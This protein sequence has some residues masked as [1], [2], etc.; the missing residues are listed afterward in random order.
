[1]ARVK[2]SPRDPNA[3]HQLSLS[4]GARTFGIK[5]A[6]GP[7]GVQETPQTPSNIR[8]TGGGQKYGD[9]DP[10]M[11]HLEQRSWEGGRAA[12]EYWQHETQ[13]YDSMNCYTLVPDRAFPAPQW[14]FGEG[15]SLADNML[16]GASR[17]FADKD[18]SWLN[19]TS[20]NLHA[21]S[22]KSDG[23]STYAMGQVQMW[24]RRIGTPPAQL[25]VSVL[26]SDG[27]DDPGTVL[28]SGTLG[29]TIIE[30]NVSKLHEFAI[31]SAAGQELG[32]A[33][34]ADYFV[35][36]NTTTAGNGNHHWEIGY[37]PTSG[38]ESTSVYSDDDG[39]SWST[40]SDVWP[41][42]RVAEPDKDRKWQFFELESGLY[43]VDRPVTNIASVLY[44]NG[45]R[46]KA[47]GSSAGSTAALI[48]TSK[49]WS[50]GLWANS[51]SWVRF[52]AG[53]GVGQKSLITASASQTLNISVPIAP[54]S[55][56]EYVIYATDEWTKIGSSLTSSAWTDAS[57]KD[58]AVLD[59]IAYVALGESTAFGKMQWNSSI[60]QFNKGSTVADKLHTF[61]DPVDGPQLWKAHA[62]TGVEV[63]RATPAAFAA[64]TSVFS[65]AISIG[66]DSHPITEIADYNDQ[67]Y[68]FKEDS[69]WTV[70]NDR[71]SRLNVGLEAMPSSNNGAVW[72]AQDFFLYFPWAHSVER[73]YSG[74]LDDIGPGRGAGLP[75]GRQGV[76]SS[77]EPVIAWLFAGIDAGSTGISSALV[78]NDRG[79]HEIFR[80]WDTGKRVEGI[81]WQ[82]CPGTQD[83]LWISV[84]GD[85]V[86]LK[87]PKDSLNPL[88]DTK[89]NYQHEAH[90]ET[91]T[92]DMGVSELPKLFDE[93]SFITKN[94]NSS[95][96]EIYAEYQ[97]DDEIGGSTWISLGRVM[98]SPSYPLKINEGDVHK[99]RLRY[100][101]LTS[102]ADNP[103]QLLAAI[104][105]GVARTPVKRLWTLRAET[106][107]FQ[108][109]AGG[110]PDHAPDD[111]YDWFQEAALKTKPL[112]MRS[113][114]ESMDDVEVYAEPAVVQRRYTTP[115]GSWG[116]LLSIS[117]REI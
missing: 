18:M 107:T 96:N 98:I 1:M 3:T 27:Q 13:F 8:I 26:T 87:F 89:M 59:N 83:R 5:A 80:A 109:T 48:D 60:H 64:S 75:S 22:F 114:W 56:T 30:E 117:I 116:G 66:D 10:M 63:F 113:I 15:F 55:D 43:A 37:G 54:A 111:F 58:V 40:R 49:Q 61:Y 95:G 46:G 23:S 25:T 108:V 47:K 103:V 69:I 65:S 24:L 32:Q 52:T 14:R 91:G 21:I 68:V 115:D 94:L 34:G 76:V 84:G 45:D 36:V 41:Y 67:L 102:D 42:F 88:N 62:T 7:L 6:G 72:A 44:I 77:L 50:T 11:S 81:K 57:V 19:L 104:L 16:P 99:I 105:K 51:D 97:L 106:G 33:G 82:P 70:K 4:D 39:T 28:G 29:S 92:F 31:S 35:Q 86:S 71:A 110:L 85:I 78:W 79:W 90:I 2:V 9:F 74:T 38:V 100:R 93:I 17:N 20:T 101:L 73:L 112:R 12:E 53:Q